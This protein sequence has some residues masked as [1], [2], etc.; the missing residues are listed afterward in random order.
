MIY[1]WIL[2]FLLGICLPI[3]LLKKNT[4]NKKYWLNILPALPAIGIAEALRRH[5]FTTWRIEAGLL[6]F[7]VVF[8]G[9]FVDIGLT[10]IL[11]RLIYNEKPNL[12]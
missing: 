7:V 4:K 5:Y 8:G 9:M 2:G 10:I 3:Y 12:K 11:Y 1:Y 6:H